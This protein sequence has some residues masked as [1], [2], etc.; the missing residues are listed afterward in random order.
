MFSYSYL[1]LSKKEVPVI[2]ASI[3]KSMSYSVFRLS[4]ANKGYWYFLSP[5]EYAIGLATA[6]AVGKMT[7]TNCHDKNA[8]ER[9][10]LIFPFMARDDLFIASN[11]FEKSAT[12][13]TKDTCGSDMEDGMDSMV[14]QMD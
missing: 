7:M 8:I 1:N 13:K 10:S 9:P 5:V 6:S 3:P 12:L 11:A 14:L 2:Q 4:S